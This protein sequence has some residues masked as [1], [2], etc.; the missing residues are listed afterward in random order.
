MDHSHGHDHGHGSHKDHDEATCTL[1]HSHGHGHDHDSHK[2]EHKGDDHSHDNG[3]EHGHDHAPK[4]KPKKVHNLSLISSVGYTIEG[5]L[6]VPLFNTF[7]SELLKEKA[8]DLFR[9]KGVLAFSGQG[10]TKFVFQGVH[11]QVN[12]GPAE[13]PWRDD[14]V[15]MS[16]MVFIGK[17]LDY[18]FFKESLLACT[19]DPTTA[20]ITMHKR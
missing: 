10:D 4:K 6:E 12:F 1:D 15:R 8:A 18:Q 20:K 14:E 17:N 16:K 5:L 13:K 19:T 7:M 3:H 2:D 9:T 11:E